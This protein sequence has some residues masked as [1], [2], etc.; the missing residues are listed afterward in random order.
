VSTGQGVI[1]FPCAELRNRVSQVLPPFPSSCTYGQLPGRAI[2]WALLTVSTASTASHSCS[3]SPG[4]FL[5]SFARSIPV[6][7]LPSRVQLPPRSSVQYANKRDYTRFDSRVRRG[8]LLDRYS[9]SILNRSHLPGSVFRGHPL[10]QGKRIV[11]LTVK[12]IEKLRGRNS[13]VS[14]SLR[15]RLE[16]FPQ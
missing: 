6:Q 9:K 13:E 15:F 14:P 16:D 8:A 10:W 2:A 7:L 1:M 5:F 3:A 4:P 11:S 12:P